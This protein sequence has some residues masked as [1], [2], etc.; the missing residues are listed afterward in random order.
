MR[1]QPVSILG[2]GVSGKGVLNLLETLNWEGRIYDEKAE[3]FDEKAAREDP[4][5]MLKGRQISQLSTFSL[6]T[7]NVQ[8]TQ[9]I[10]TE[11]IRR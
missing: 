2:N 5:R 3:L 9:K 11:L 7:R 6:G 8:Q 10:L 4:P 1:S